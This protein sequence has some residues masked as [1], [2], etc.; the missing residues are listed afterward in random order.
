[1]HQELI[2]HQKALKCMW[3]VVLSYLTIVVLMLVY[4]LVE[5]LDNSTSCLSISNNIPLNDSLWFL[6]RSVNTY[7]WILP[8]T[9]LFWPKV[10]RGKALSVFPREEEEHGSESEFYDG[11]TNSIN[12]LSKG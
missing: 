1:M 12:S 7:V 3:V 8:I 2:A 10:K 9:Y 11:D 5:Y 6:T 4:D